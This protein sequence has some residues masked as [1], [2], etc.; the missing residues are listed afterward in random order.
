MMIE[1]FFATKNRNKVHEIQAL[2]SGLPFELRS[3]LDEPQLPAAD[4]VGE[5]LEENALLKAELAVAQLGIPAFADDTGLFVDALGG[6][7]GIYA[8]RYAGADATYRDNYE[9]L[10]RELEHV[11]DERRGAEFRC[12][13]A[14]LVPDGSSLALPR[15]VEVVQ[16]A[17]ARGFLARGAIRGAITRSPSGAG[18]FGYDPVFFVPD[19]GCTFAELDGPQKNELSHRGRAVRHFVAG[20]SGMR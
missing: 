3:C 1:L 15:E 7:P 20:L 17:A 18:G 9:K 6:A 4:E 14:F 10:L 2:L 5:T 13:I 11:P 12:V 19:A 8:A 16:R